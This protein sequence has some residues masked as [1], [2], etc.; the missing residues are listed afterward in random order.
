MIRKI[1]VLIAFG[2]RPEAIKMAPLVNILET[3][4][5]FEVKVLVTGQHKEML[6]QVLDIFEIIPDFDLELMDSKQTLSELASKI[7]AK[8]DPILKEFSPHIV[9]VHGDTL[10]ANYIAQCAFLNK[11]DVGH[12]EAGLRTNNLLSPWPEEANRQL[13]SRISCL[14]FAPTEE[15]RQNLLKEN[16]N[17][18]SIRVVGNTVIDALLYISKQIDGKLE[19]F[20]HEQSRTILVTSHRRENF[21]QSFENICDAIKEIALNRPNINIIFPVH[22]NPYVYEMVH[23]KLSGLS[24]VSLIDPLDYVEFIRQMKSCYLILTD[25]GGIQEEAPSLNKPV[26]V[27]RDTTERIEAV[28]VGTVKLIGTNQQN[29]IDSVIGLLDNSAEYEMMANAR[30]PYGDGYTAQKIIEIIAEYYINGENK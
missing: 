23:T 3:D 9:L 16:V 12:V 28:E 13:I 24:N 20:C 18:N 30:N 14:H 25:S 27:M 2:T 10:T 15:N 21:G 11:I 26:L 6:Y 5:R 19:A 1:K 7:L 8:A 4:N 22:K 17:D 29:I